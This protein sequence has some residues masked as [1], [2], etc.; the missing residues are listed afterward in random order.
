MDALTN[1]TA[2]MQIEISMMEKVEQELKSQCNNDIDMIF[3]FTRELQE[4]IPDIKM[5]GFLIGVDGGF[6]A[7]YFAG[8]VRIQ[9]SLESGPVKSVHADGSVVKFNP[10]RK[11]SVIYGD[12]YFINL[13]VKEVIDRIKRIKQ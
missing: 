3:Q 7:V 11:V 2:N 13:T 12:E 1:S 6:R 5:H 10:D 9:L 8:T 4:V